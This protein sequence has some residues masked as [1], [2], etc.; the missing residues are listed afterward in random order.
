M[1][2]LLGS[3]ATAAILASGIMD[4]DDYVRGPLPLEAYVAAV[5]AAAIEAD[6]AAIGACT[7][8]RTLEAL[9]IGLI[10][11][12][13]PIANG[14]REGDRRV[15]REKF[16]VKGCGPD[17]QVNLYVIGL[18]TEAPKFVGGVPGTT[19][20]GYFVQR[21]VLERLDPQARESFAGEG[22]TDVRL[23]GTSVDLAMDAGGQWRENWSYDGCG[24]KARYWVELTATRE[25]VKF[26]TSVPVNVPVP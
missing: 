13:D 25:G 16:L 5:S 1:S 2:L 17:R 26:E 9:G 14:W 21:Q 10:L 23:Y 7:E 18:P 15:Y 8:A 12:A 22:C 24:L 20:T 19:E 11:T 6:D 4:R 3:A